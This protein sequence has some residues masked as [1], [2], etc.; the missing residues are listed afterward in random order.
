M[1]LDQGIVAPFE[2][3]LCCMSL[4]TG[5]L[6]MAIMGL[7]DLLLLV[8]WRYSPLGIVGLVSSLP[9]LYGTYKANRNFLWPYLIVRLLAIF[10]G[11]VVVSIMVFAPTVLESN[12]VVIFKMGFAIILYVLSFWF[13]FSYNVELRR[14]EGIENENPPPQEL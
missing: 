2:T 5:S 12:N 9:L 1:L 10:V 8:G 11:I 6:V 7:W 4:R 13:V 3:F 14:N